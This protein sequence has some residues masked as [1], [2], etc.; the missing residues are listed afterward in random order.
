VHQDSQQTLIG[1][2]KRG[3]CAMLRRQVLRR[4]V[5]Y[6]YGA[7]AARL[8]PRA[9]LGKVTAEDIARI[10]TAVADLYKAGAIDP[11]QQQA[12]DVQV[13]LPERKATTANVDTG[14]QTQDG[15]GQGAPAD[16][17][18]APGQPG[19]PAPGQPPA[20]APTPTPAPAP[21]QQ[22]RRAA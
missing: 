14:A 1:Q 21:A 15:Q 19:Q 11:S 12:L 13:N 2:A 6:N 10:W 20:P 3:V 9:S 7:T 22:Q 18:P 8:T 4:L 16:A 5:T 17:P